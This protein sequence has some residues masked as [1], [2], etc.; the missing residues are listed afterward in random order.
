MPCGHTSTPMTL[1]STTVVNL[2]TRTLCARVS[3]AA[4]TI[5]APGANHVTCSWAPTKLRLSGSDRRQIWPAEQLRLFNSSWIDYCTIV[6][7]RPR[8]PSSSGQRA[9]HAAACHESNRYLLVCY[10]QL[11]RLRQI[12]RRVGSEVTTQLVLALV[13]IGLLQVLQRNTGRLTTDYD[14]NNNNNNNK[15]ISWRQF[16]VKGAAAYI[17]FIRY[18]FNSF[19]KA[20]SDRALLRTAS[21]KPFQTRGAA[22]AKER[23]PKDVFILTTS[24][25]WRPVQ[26]VPERR[27]P[28]HQQSVLRY[29]GA[30]SPASPSCNV[31]AAGLVASG[32]PWAPEW[33]DRS[34][35]YQSPD[36]QLHSEL[37]IIASAVDR[38]RQTAVSYNS[39]DGCWWTHEPAFWL[40]LVSVTVL[41][42]GAVA[43]D[44]SLIDRGWWYE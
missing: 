38:Q 10:Y 35:V 13:K 9:V 15:F 28:A 19:A 29:S 37:T 24:S 36:G 3:Q 21:G 14:N 39:Q 11:R 27:L 4:Q 43:V 33:Y 40:R 16:S 26:R 1:S 34:V 7:C 25:I 44:N 2:A 18:V 42:H 32:G 31:C 8:S 20:S 30:R 17:Q 23:S 22:A 41:Y 5:S 6:H 12:R